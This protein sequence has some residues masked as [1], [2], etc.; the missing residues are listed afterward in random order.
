MAYKNNIFKDKTVITLSTISIVAAAAL[1][2]GL[3]LDS[4]EKKA[5]TSGNEIVDLNESYTT[6]N[7]VED[8]SYEEPSTK[9]PVSVAEVETTTSLPEEE[10]TTEVTVNAPANSLNFTSSSILTWPVDGNIIIDY[11]MNNTVYF[12]TL[13]LYKC[14]DSICIQ[15]DVG[16]PVY[17]STK[18]VV[19]DIGYNE[20]IGNYV[21]MDLGNGYVLT[22][23][24]LNDIVIAKNDIVDE[25]ELIGYI[26]NPTDYYCVEGPNLYLQLT[27][28]GTPVDPL[29]YLN[30]E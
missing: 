3:A 29:D 6:S 30:Y 10:T 9:E 11:D 18:G 23:G 1:I 16:T 14:S 26:A 19:S 12:P 13:D 25:Y 27:E 7:P 21:I 15:S 24:Q 8:D 2:G 17:A 28:N 5:S 22:Y 20:E 4:G